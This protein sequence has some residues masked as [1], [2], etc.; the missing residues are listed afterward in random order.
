[1]SGTSAETILFGEFELDLRAGELRRG[2]SRIRLQEQPFQI[3]LMLLERPGGVVTREEIRKR[4]WPN[5]TVVEFDH[6]I[7]TAI[8]KLRQA[9]DDEAGSPRYVETLPRRGFRFIFPA[10]EVLNT[11]LPP[12]KA[13]GEPAAVDPDPQPAPNAPPRPSRSRWHLPVFV[14]AAVLLAAAAF[15]AHSW[16]RHGRGESLDE[17]SLTQVTTSIGVDIY[18]SLSPD[19]SAVVYSS[20]KNGGFEI[21]VKTLAPG[22][23]EI[24][25]T[26]DGN[27]N[28][29]PAWSPDGTQIAFF[30]DKKGGIWM[31]PALGGTARRLTEFGGKPVWSPD[32]SRI[33]FQSAGILDYSPTGLAITLPSST[34][35]MVD[36]RGGAPTQLTQP[37]N[38]NGGH[39]APTWSPDGKQIAFS[40]V[41]ASLQEIWTIPA[42]G[43]TPRR[44]VAGGVYDPVYGPGG[45]YLYFSKSFVGSQQ[46]TPVALTFALMRVP[47]SPEGA[48]A[49]EPELAKD[50]GPVVYRGLRFSANGQFLVFS[51]VAANDNL[52]SIRISP[53]TGEAV[54]DPVPFTH[55]TML[56]KLD[57]LF[58]P[59]G[60]QIAYTVIQNGEDTGIGM[61]VADT[62]G[63]NAH[64]VGATP[65]DR[66]LIGWLPVHGGLTFQGEQKGHKVLDSIDLSTGTISVLRELAEDGASFRV[67]PDGR[68]IA[69]GKREGGAVN[70]WVAPIG[71]GQAGD[72]PAK[73]LTFG[74]GLMSYPCW[75]PDGKTIAF[76]IENGIATV[77]AAGGPV[78]VLQVGEREPDMLWDWAPDGDKIVFA[79][80][81]NAATNL[82]WISRSTRQQKQLTHYSRDNSYVRYP[83]W[84]PRGDQIVYEYSETTGN[85]WTMRVK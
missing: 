26:N 24:Q 20:D 56:R 34:L 52:Q 8:K 49:G 57:P 3:L 71:F 12:E 51:A 62:D 82:F 10:V 13:V 17:T 58:S 80:R 53:S 14:S 2:T 39:G 4:L 6:S 85:I 61:W 84:S 9:L 37:G 28:L 59:D 36:A 30:S 41:S 79:N 23:R 66:H 15:I 44:L 65:T 47:L 25:L 32:G 83:A 18:P 5:D 21:Y 68:Q 63:K 81:R 55:D 75:S 76:E 1:V 22:G 77:P 69:F 74:K 27:G 64:P 42:N 29:Q 16:W 78:T 40:S 50:S 11:E 70:V 45:R 33:V 46:Q 31:I 72:G 73:Q 35:W 43:G 54:G 38:P 7:G 60:A 67:S 48:V 19:G